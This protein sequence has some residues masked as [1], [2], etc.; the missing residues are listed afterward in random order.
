MFPWMWIWCP[1]YHYPWSGA[2][3][4]KIDPDTDWFFSAI[5]TKA[6]NGAVEAKAFHVASYGRQLGLISEVLLH[7][8][9]S[10]SI[11][12]AL[13]QQSLRRLREINQR[14]DELKAEEASSTADALI[15]QLRRLKTDHPAEFERVLTLALP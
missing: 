3:A 4:Q 8:A 14:I 5:P 6:G 1:I 15:A 12:P 10:G 13:A 7:V 9:D 11:D 2:V